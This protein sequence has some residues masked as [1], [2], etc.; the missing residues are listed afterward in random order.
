LLKYA[1]KQ[2][3]SNFGCC[4]KYEEILI[5]YT[6]DGL[7][8]KNRVT[9]YCHILEHVFNKPVIVTGEDSVTVNIG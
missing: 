4:P 8:G 9:Y 6:L 1:I 5:N 2:I 7:I 3:D